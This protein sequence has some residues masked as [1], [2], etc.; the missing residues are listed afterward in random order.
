[1]EKITIDE[2]VDELVLKG[3]FLNL[4]I[5]GKGE[6]LYQA[7]SERIYSPGL[8]IILRKRDI[9]KIFFLVKIEFLK[10]LIFYDKNA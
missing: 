9:E 3:D 6:L 8:K 2:L 4:I 1:M 5:E 7:K 10:F